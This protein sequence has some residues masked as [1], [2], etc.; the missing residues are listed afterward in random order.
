MDLFLRIIQAA[1]IYGA[2][3]GAIYFI[4]L[5]RESKKKF[6][7]IQLPKTLGIFQNLGK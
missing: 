6:A 2:F 5:I 7:P 3:L 4:W 1:I